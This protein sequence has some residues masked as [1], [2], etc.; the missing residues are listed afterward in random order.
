MTRGFL[1]N[2]DREFLCPV[3]DRL[4]RLHEAYKQTINSQS[5]EAALRDLRS[6]LSDRSVRRSL[7]RLLRETTFDQQLQS[8]SRTIQAHELE[9]EGS[10]GQLFGLSDKQIRRH[11]NKLLASRPWTFDV[12]PL[13]L[14]STADLERLIDRLHQHLLTTSTAVTSSRWTPFRKRRLSQQTDGVIFCIGSVLADSL[15]TAYFRLSYSLAVATYWQMG[16]A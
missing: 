15:H 2:D 3:L 10:L 4:Q 8:G 7:D 14:D 16:L 6:E 9:V 13:Q 5:T 1:L 12:Q 11:I